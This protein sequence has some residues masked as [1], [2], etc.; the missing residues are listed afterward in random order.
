MIISTSARKSGDESTKRDYRPG[1][2]REK[3]FGYARLGAPHPAAMVR[4]AQ[5]TP[6]N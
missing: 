5:A 3:L 6:G 2:Y 1:T 4:S